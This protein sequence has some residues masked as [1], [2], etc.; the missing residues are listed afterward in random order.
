[1]SRNYRLLL[2]LLLVVLAACGGKNKQPAQ[3]D[4]PQ[5][6]AEG[7]EGGGGDQDG[8]SVQGDTLPGRLL[9]VQRGVVWMWAGGEARPLFGEGVAWQPEW[10]PDGERIVYIERGQSYSD[11]MLADAQ[12]NHLNQ[13]TFYGSD[14]Q[15]ESHERIYDTMWAF[16][17]TWTPE[18]KRITI[19]S[20]YGPPAGAPAVEANLALYTISTGGSGRRQLF[21]DTTAHCGNM[22]YLPT[23]SAGAESTRGL[24]YTHIS[25]LQDGVQQLSWLD[26]SRGVSEPV[27]GAPEHSY[28]PAFSADGRWLAFAVSGEELT[29]VWAL[30]GTAV[31]AEQAE[32]HQLTMMGSARAPEF[33]PDGSLLAFL[34][35]PP[36][37]GGFDLWV[38]DVSEQDGQLVLGTPRQLTEDMALD[39][40]S[41]L[42]WAP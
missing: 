36:G 41:G 13:L 15:L 22:D 40:D 31:S 24:V 1:V 37:K 21:T 12:G 6:G 20:Q 33:S 42:S 34:A 16:Y 14:R 29:D 39:A 2:I 38:A 30:P 8:P 19:V 26:I 7:S 18:G 10:S 28:D 11:V 9:F 27:P 3:P 25:T 32:P 23:G 4:N 35:I 5:Q 17:P